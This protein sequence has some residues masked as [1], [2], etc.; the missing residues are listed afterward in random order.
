MEVQL[1]SASAP[2]Q[3][4]VV[5]RTHAG[6]TADSL[7]GAFCH[8]RGQEYD[9][10]LALYTRANEPLRG[11]AS[12][13]ALRVRPGDT[14]YV[15]RQRSPHLFLANWGLLGALCAVLGLLGLLVVSM[16]YG[17]TGGRV[18]FVHGVVVDAGS[19]HSEA[20]LYRWEGA[21]YL[22]TGRVVQ[23]DHRNAEP[24]I[25]SLGPRRTGPE[26]E[27]AVSEV[28]GGLKAPVY[29]GATAGMRLLNLTNPLEAEAV[30]MAAECALNPLGL[31]RASILSGHE[32]GLFAWLSSNY[33]FNR[34]PVEAEE[35]ATYGAVD[36]GG[37]STQIAFQVDTNISSGVS[38]LQLYGRRYDVFAITYLCY[39][40]NEVERRF[41]AHIVAQQN[42]SANVR[43]PCH[44]VG[45]SFNRTAEDVLGSYC[46]QTTANK[47]W[48]QK[49]PPTFEFTFVGEGSA[50][51]CEESVA[52]LMDLSECRKLYS[53]CMEP[54]EAP[55]PHNRQF[56]GFSAFYYT[57]KALN[58]SKTSLS[59]FKNASD[60]LCSA[61]WEDALKTG[62]PQRYLSRYCLQ[63]MYIRDVLLDKYKFTEATWPNLMFTKKANG[64]DVGW[65]L[66]FMINATNA[67]PAARPSL[68]SIGRN[69]FILLVVLFVLLLALAAAF[70][71]LA[72]KQS[73][74]RLVPPS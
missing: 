58:S 71:L 20:T 33:L 43:S 59:A 9:P 72:R 30:L 46:T 54:P 49:N 41:L 23:V 45:Y 18:P 5:V 61:S 64:F 52:Q 67:I 73:R 15:R 37:A 1:K 69:L 28:L 55:V 50:A 2:D 74:A 3:S 17:L 21:K 68:P 39:G 13:D 11:G 60:W 47:E 32:E 7:L 40:V 57:L 12:L 56:I 26:L 10:S 35:V 29:L 27:K 19:S 62:I 24:G 65:S 42:Y 25:S 31:Q 38:S 6:A 63:A 44:N 14:L 34:I 51:K 22:G 36:L 48:L 66:G 8:D 4:P 53:E 70:L 16:A